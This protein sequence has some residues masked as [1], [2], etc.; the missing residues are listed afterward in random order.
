MIIAI[1]SSNDND[2]IFSEAWVFH[3]SFS[4]FIGSLLFDDQT[5]W[6]MFIYVLTCLQGIS[7]NDKLMF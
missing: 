5:F 3:L 7:R 1:N 4:F 2:M 6:V